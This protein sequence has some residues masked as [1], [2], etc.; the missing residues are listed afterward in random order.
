MTYEE[1]FIAG[2]EHAYQWEPI[3]NAPKDRSMI[4]V[5]NSDVA[6]FAWKEDAIC[7]MWF[8]EKGYKLSFTPTHWL[9]LPTLPKGPT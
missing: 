7:D 8:T 3:E 1:G 6:E 4:L 5:A 2:I 9:P